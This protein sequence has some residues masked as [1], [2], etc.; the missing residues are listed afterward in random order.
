MKRAKSSGGSIH[1]CHAILSSRPLVAQLLYCLPPLPPCPH[2]S[3]TAAFGCCKC[4]LP[5]QM[6]CALS[7]DG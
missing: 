4:A 2:A 3:D 5:E 1:K 7:H 6:R